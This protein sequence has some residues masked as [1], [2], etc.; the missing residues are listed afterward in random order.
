MIKALGSK[1]GIQ[2]VKDMIVCEGE[3]AGIRAARKQF[4]YDHYSMEIIM[5]RED[6]DHYKGGI[7]LRKFLNSCMDKFA[8]DFEKPSTDD[9]KN[10]IELYKEDDSLDIMEF[11]RLNCPTKNAVKQGLDNSLEWPKKVPFEYWAEDLVRAVYIN[12]F[13][14]YYFDSSIDDMVRWV[15][16]DELHNPAFVNAVNHCE[17]ALN[18]DMDRN[19]HLDDSK[20]FW[21]GRNDFTARDEAKNENND[22][23]QKAQ[24]NFNELFDKWV[25]D[26]PLGDT[27]IFCR[28]YREEALQVYRAAIL[29]M[30]MRENLSACEKINDSDDYGRYA[31][32]FAKKFFMGPDVVEVIEKKGEKVAYEVFNW[33]L[34]VS[35]LWRKLNK[36]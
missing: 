22:Y 24:D 7:P 36:I 21:G 5:P 15:T 4:L 35:T 8:D 16:Q 32:Q 27:G 26:L 28:V 1:E 17:T 31:F 30:L 9:F 3:E 33:G 12:L 14:L 18:I 29:V 23:A 6:Y 20:P 11:A 2:L 34:S 25:N 13:G 10:P 19:L